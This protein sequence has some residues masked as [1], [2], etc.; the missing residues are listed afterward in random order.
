[1]SYKGVEAERQLARYLRNRGYHTERSAG[2]RGPIDLYAHKQKWGGIVKK[3]F[4]I[5]VKATTE[6]ELRIEKKAIEDLRKA[7]SSASLE[8][9]LAVRF[10]RE[11]WKVWWDS[12]E[13]F[14]LEETD[15]EYLLNKYKSQSNIFL[16]ADDPRAKLLEKVFS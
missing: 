15:F 12:E 11:N 8:P 7:A 6:S 9:I 14:P 2:S 13:E 4:A 3:K 5:Q 10:G 16:R 1:L